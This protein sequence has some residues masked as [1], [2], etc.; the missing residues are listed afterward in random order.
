MGMEQ[1]L[2][3]IMI[4]VHMVH[5]VHMILMIHTKHTHMVVKTMC[6]RL[7]HTTCRNICI[8]HKA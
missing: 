6:L 3:G 7:R 1:W 2:M 8:I 5:M 4:M